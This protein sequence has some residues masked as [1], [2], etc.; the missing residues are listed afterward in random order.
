VERIVHLVGSVF[1][2]FDY[3][4]VLMRHLDEGITHFGGLSGSMR[5]TAQSPQR[6]DRHKNNMD[7][8]R[9]RSLNR[10]ARISVEISVASVK[11]AQMRHPND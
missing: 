4:V 5:I 3:V 8:L 9:R 1:Y 6:V 11:S 2:S 7:F 10:R